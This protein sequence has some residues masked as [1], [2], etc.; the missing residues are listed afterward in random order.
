MITKEM[1]EALRKSLN[2]VAYV[3]VA[4]ATDA[5][6][7]AFAAMPGPANEN[8]VVTGCTANPDAASVLRFIE[9]FSALTPAPDLASENERLRAALEEIIVDCQGASVCGE[10][11]MGLEC[12]YHKASS[13][14]E[15]T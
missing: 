4:E 9:K 6:T 8:L 15:R 7:A 14:L 10:A 11:E 5:I 1:I 13:A 3:S 12:I 2:S